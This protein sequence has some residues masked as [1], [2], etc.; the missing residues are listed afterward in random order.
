MKKIIKMAG[1]IIVATLMLVVLAGCGSENDYDVLTATLEEQG[2]RT[3]DEVRFSGDRVT[4]A[5]VTIELES[6]EEAEERAIVM[7]N[8]NLYGLTDVSRSGRTV[9][10]TFTGSGYLDALYLEPTAT[11]E[12]VIEVLEEERICN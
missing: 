10:L 1:I 12:E 7:N 9:V 5:T 11:R 8:M 6:Q 2:T 4:S 3:T